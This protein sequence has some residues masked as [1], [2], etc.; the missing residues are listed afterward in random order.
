V[1]TSRHTLQRKIQT[2]AESF[3]LTAK[4]NAISG[5]LSF[6]RRVCVQNEVTVMHKV[7]GV[8][9]GLPGR[10]THRFHTNVA[11]VKLLTDSNFKALKDQK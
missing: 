4:R 5:N 10:V 1:R 3:T 9:F 2:K 11:L 6:L 7:A 8:K